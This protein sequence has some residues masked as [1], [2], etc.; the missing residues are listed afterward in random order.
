MTPG[1]LLI[2]G[3]G[4]FGLTAALELRSRGWKV[5]LIDP[6]V[7][8]HPDAASTDI[9]KVVRMD[10]ATDEQHTAMGVLSIE[11]W[12][13]WNR[14]WG[15][16]LYHEDGFLVM[17]RDAMSPGGFEHDSFYY[18]RGLGHTLHRTDA[19]MLRDKHPDWN[20]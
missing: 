8:P 2:L 4:C 1:S 3:G 10:Y 9:S 11:R 7:L 15:A 18:L 17:S 19:A 5:T 6:G 13:A 14:R 12:K 16:D 20:A